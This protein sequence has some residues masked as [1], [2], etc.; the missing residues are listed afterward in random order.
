[1]YLSRHCGI[2]F[3]FTS[4]LNRSS[5]LDSLAPVEQDLT[6]CIDE[7]G[8]KVNSN[9]QE[10]EFDFDD[11]IVNRGSG[12]IDSLYEAC[13]KGIKIQ[14]NFS[15][16]FKAP[17]EK[18]DATEKLQIPFAVTESSKVTELALGSAN[19]AHALLVNLHYFIC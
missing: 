19:S 14:N 9:R 17:I 6:T 18:R 15:D 12:F 13:E 7:N 2:S 1:M 3:I 4:K 11:V 16:V 10:Y 8:K 5:T